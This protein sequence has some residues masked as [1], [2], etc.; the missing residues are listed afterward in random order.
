[1]YVILDTQAIH[2]QFDLLKNEDTREL[3][4]HAAERGL[5]VCVPEV[6]IMEM[7]ADFRERAEER[8]RNVLA[9]LTRDDA[10]TSPVIDVEKEVEEYQL[11]LNAQ[12]EQLKVRVLPVPRSIS[13]Q[14]L[15][16]RGIRRRKPFKGNGRGLFDALIWGSVVELW[17]NAP[18]RYI[19]MITGDPD[20]ADKKYEDPNNAR[21]HPDLLDDLGIPSLEAQSIVDYET[22]P[23]NTGNAGRAELHKSIQAFNADW[24]RRM[25]STMKSEGSETESKQGDAP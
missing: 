9:R 6:V 4:E 19:A 13:V 22:V 2:W 7:T 12:L 17:R 10:S 20:Y 1:M 15:L 11:G 21:L 16:E 23:E 3:L 24:R 5:E 14:E 8:L 18:I 25:G